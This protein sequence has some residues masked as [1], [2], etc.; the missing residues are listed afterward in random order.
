MQGTWVAQ[1]VKCLTLAQVMISQFVSSSPLSGSL[2]SAQSLLCI[3]CPP[4]SLPLP[5]TLALKNKQKKKYCFGI[6]INYR[7]FRSHI[8]VKYFKVTTKIM[9]H[10]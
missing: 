6:V 10:I 8:Q 2:L 4:L 3:L 7:L 5:H 1:L 9:K